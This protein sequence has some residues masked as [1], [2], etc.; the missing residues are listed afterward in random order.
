[1][2]RYPYF[3]EGMYDLWLKYKEQMK[4]EIPKLEK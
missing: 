4:V 2:Q 3:D 1:M